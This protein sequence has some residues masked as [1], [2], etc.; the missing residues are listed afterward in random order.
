MFN[1]RHFLKSEV[2]SLNRTFGCLAKQ[3]LHLGIGVRLT[4]HKLLCFFV[5]CRVRL[6]QYAT[7]Y[8]LWSL[9]QRL[10][11]GSEL[12][13]VLIFWLNELFDH[14]KTTVLVTHEVLVH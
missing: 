14:D 1:S 11:I 10:S 4:F 12:G 2:S 8:E 9:N 6:V 5:A 13:R 3:F 7:L